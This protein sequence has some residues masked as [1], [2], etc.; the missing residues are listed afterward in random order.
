MKKLSIIIPVYNEEKTIGEIVKRVSDVP[1]SGYEKEIIVVN[2]GSDDGTERLLKR[3]KENS[4]FILL[5]HNANLGKGAAIKTALTRVTGNLVLIQ[6]ADMEYDPNDYQ[7]L[8]A[9]VDTE[10]PVIY[11]SRN[12]GRAERGHFLYFLGGKFLTALFNILFG[13]HLTDINTGYKLFPADLIKSISL[14]SNGFEFCEEITAKIYTLGY[15]VKE[16]PI[17]YTPRSFSEG[18]KISALDGLIG[19]WTIIKY[20]FD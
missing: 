5:E 15:R 2:D 1:L 16:I 10:S 9:A 20:R 18:K 7:E 12:L 3:L 6:D 4:G 13:A 8:L 17:H 11:G 19:I 14:E